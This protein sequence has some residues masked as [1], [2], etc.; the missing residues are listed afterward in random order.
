MR[1]HRSVVKV[2]FFLTGEY[3]IKY[4]VSRIFLVIWY[5]V[6]QGE[7]WN[8][9]YWE[10]K[11]VRSVFLC[12]YF[13]TKWMN[14]SIIVHR[15]LLLFP[16]SQAI[17]EFYLE[18]TRLWRRSNFGANFRFLRKKWTGD[19]LYPSKQLVIRRNNVRRIWR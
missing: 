11:L 12:I 14:R 8:V 17:F 4:E 6:D 13:K 10:Y 18:K 7:R 16:I 9:I 19:L 5:V 1:N 15:C 2:K 3:F